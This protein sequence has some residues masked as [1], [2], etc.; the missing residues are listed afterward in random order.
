MRRAPA[1]PGEGRTT[2][3][4]PSSARRLTA[5][6]LIGSCAGA[7]V[8]SPLRGPLIWAA[9][10]L[11]VAFTALKRPQWLLYAT[12]VLAFLPTPAG[13]PQS[14]TL[15]GV[16]IWTFEPTLVI[17]FVWALWKLPAS[18]ADWMRVGALTLVL[19]S[20][21]LVGL[22][23]GATR[24]EI[25]GDVRGFAELAMGFTIMSRVIEGP[26]IR[27]CLT[28]IRWVLWASAALTMTASL[29]GLRLSGRVEDA[30]LS[31][32]TGSSGAD[33]LLTS[34]TWPALAALAIVLSFA[35]VGRIRLRTAL[36]YAL[37]AV[38]IVFLAYSRNSLLVLTVAPLLTVLAH[39]SVRVTASA[40]VRVTVGV[41][42]TALTFALLVVPLSSLA[43]GES[44]LARQLRG[45]SSRVL[46][47]VTQSGLD[48][49]SSAN[50]RRLENTYLFDALREAPV[51]G[52]GFGFPYLPARGVPGGFEATIGRYYAENFYLWLLVKCGLIGT[53][54][55]LW[56]LFGVVMAALRSRDSVRVALAATSAGLLVAS[57]VSGVPE[58]VPG[59][60]A[61][62][63]LVGAAAQQGR[64]RVGH[65]ARHRRSRAAPDDANA[66]SG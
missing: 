7:I 64:Y 17:C 61:L 30:A 65:R 42:A 59:S 47:G 25:V 9:G 52:H 55:V 56:A 40:L 22:Y 26:H 54:L 29:T 38:V 18:R 1:P 53:A 49:D 58:G 14:L 3:A 50:Y 44:W 63:L 60:L 21:T 66:P 27:G 8:A 4:S 16:T 24:P 5:E 39:R 19:A 12:L 51:L 36:S 41:V 28:T 13:V 31:N 20:W 34:A 32:V 37:P 43:G 62:G 45:F 33:R 6:L 23:G 48:R 10:A 2:S 35:V 57:V 46:Q 15:L 11:L